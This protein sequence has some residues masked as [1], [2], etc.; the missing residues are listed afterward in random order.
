[1]CQARENDKW[2]TPVRKL[3]HDTV[4]DSIGSAL[5]NLCCAAHFLRGLRGLQMEVPY[6]NFA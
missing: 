1:V 3:R 4:Q 2:I 6:A 5:D